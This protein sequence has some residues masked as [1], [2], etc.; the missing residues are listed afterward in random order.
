MLEGRHIAITGAA[1]GIGLAA[2]RLFA[3]YGASLLLIDRDRAVEDVAKDVPDAES[4]IADISDGERIADIFAGQSS[5]DG[6]FNNAGIEG[7]GG[8]MVAM[9]SY[10]VEEFRKVLSINVE[11]MWHCMRAQISRFS[12]AGG[13]AIVNT[14]SVMGWRGAPGL[15]AY[16]ASK[17][18]VIGLTRTAALETAQAGVRVNAVLPGAIETPMLTERGFVRNPDFAEQAAMA[19]PMGRIGRAEEVAEAAAWLLSDK[20][21]FVTGHCLAVDGGFSA[22]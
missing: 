20:A 12:G 13:G 6:A 2:A 19:H 8:E 17:H 4:C 1:S 16:S 10:P 5:L 22:R 9:E 7:M 21:S 14:A 15:S 11:G 3:G 18:A